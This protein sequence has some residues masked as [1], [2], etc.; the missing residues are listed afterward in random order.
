[1]TNK[2]KLYIYVGP[3]RSG[4]HF[5]NDNIMPNVPEVYSTFS[6]DKSV[7]TILLN[8]MESHHLFFDAASVRKQVLERLADVKEDIILINSAEFFGD[9]GHHNSDGMYISQPFYDNPRRAQ[10]LK[11]VFDCPEFE[12]PKVMMSMRRQDTWIESAYMHYIHNYRIFKFE[13]FITPNKGSNYRGPKEQGRIPGVDWRSLDWSVYVKNYFQIFGKD[14]VLVLPFEMG[15]KDLP[16]YLKRLFY[17]L[18][19]PPYLPDTAP[20]VNHS[21]SS[22]ALKWAL[23]L[24][25]LVRQPEN[26]YG[27]IPLQPFAGWLKK[28]RAVRDTKLLWALAGIS[29]RISLLWFLRHVVSKYNYQ[30]PDLLGETLRN[31][32]LS[33]YKESNKAY[34]EMI[35][36]DLSKYDYY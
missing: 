17:F 30:R 9:Y 36:V 14:N 35:G 11:D 16:L 4:S 32:I 27:F 20:L 24:G 33:H 15:T 2:K 1:M 8:A 21:I 5:L 29:R 12:S 31:Q 26:P 23:I 28:K 10:I 19:V 7:N 13:N 34:A 25:P 22:A 6:R 3:H 18:D